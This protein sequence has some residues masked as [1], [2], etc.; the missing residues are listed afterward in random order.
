MFTTPEDWALVAREMFAKAPDARAQF[1]DFDRLVAQELCDKGAWN[2]LEGFYAE[3]ALG[4]LKPAEHENVFGSSTAAF[5][6]GVLGMLRDILPR[7]QKDR[8]IKAIYCE[9]TLD[10]NNLCRLTTHLCT[11][12]SPDDEQWATNT[13]IRKDTIHGPAVAEV[14]PGVIG[15]RKDTLAS[16][17]SLAY[18]NARL[19]A[20]W[21]RA[22]ETL[23]P[24][25]PLAFSRHHAPVVRLMPR[26]TTKK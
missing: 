12:F 21:G 14:F 20:A 18:A 1:I 26:Q 17:I 25:L 4:S 6:A 19:L 15:P 2:E 13:L 24:A 10:A 16:N 23:N 5:E 8:Q 9:Y 11:A 7:A 22:V 3:A